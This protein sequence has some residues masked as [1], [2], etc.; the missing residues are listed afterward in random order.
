MNQY[1]AVMSECLTVK[2][3]KT[4]LNSVWKDRA[5]WRMIGIQLNFLDS[6]LDAIKGNCE[7]MD[8]CFIKLISKWLRQVDPKPTWAALV[9]ALNSPL[10]DCKDTARTIEKT[11]LQKELSLNAVGNEHGLPEIDLPPSKHPLQ[12]EMDRLDGRFTDLV[13]KTEK[14]L[15]NSGNFSVP[16][17]RKLFGRFP[18]TR[19]HQHKEFLDQYYLQSRP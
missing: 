18:S 15:E 19:R 12:E 2:D 6:D 4:V 5:K 14:C 11:Y 3:Q 13:G 17:F 8:H 10:V 1:S 7:N 9:D 16:F